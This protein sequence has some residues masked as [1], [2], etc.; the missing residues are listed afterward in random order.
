[1]LGNLSGSLLNPFRSETVSKIR[2][3]EIRTDMRKKKNRDDQ[4]NP[5][6][7]IS[8]HQYIFINFYSYTTKKAR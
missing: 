6:L 1:M 7:A 4:Q 3:I 2:E 5:K 8:K